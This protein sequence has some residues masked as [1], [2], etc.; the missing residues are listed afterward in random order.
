MRVLPLVLCALAA[1]TPSTQPVDTSDTGLDCA[2]EADQT[3]VLWDGMLLDTQSAMDVVVTNPCDQA[4]SLEMVTEGDEAFSVPRATLPLVAGET[5]T[6]QVL[7]QSADLEAH[8]GELVLSSLGGSARV[9]LQGHNS[10]DW[11]GDGHQGEL[12]GG[13]DCD[14]SQSSIHPDAVE[15]PCD[16]VDS[17]CDGALD[18]ASVGAKEYSDLNTAFEE[19]GNGQ[20]IWI[21]PGT[22]PLQAEVVGKDLNLLPWDDEADPPV[23]DGESSGRILDYDTGILEITGMVFANG[24][25]VGDGG[26]IRADNAQ[27]QLQGVG[28]RDNTA[29]GEGGAIAADMAHQ[30]FVASLSSFEGNTAGTHGGAVAL[31]A[32]G[33][34][35]LDGCTVDANTASG[36]DG[37]GILAE[38]Y[39]DKPAKIQITDSA[40]SNNSASGEGGGL[41]LGQAGYAQVTLREATFASNSA[42]QGGGLGA[43]TDDA[44]E[45]TLETCSF[46][47]NRADVGG[48]VHYHGASLRGAL[49]V[50]GGSYSNNS[51]T[52]QGGGFNVWSAGS[53]GMEMSS[54]VNLSACSAP[55][56]GAI[57]LDGDTNWS[58]SFEK[59]NFLSNTGTQGAALYLGSVSLLMRESKVNSNTATG[60]GAAYVGASGMLTSR[61]SNWGSGSTENEDHDVVCASGSAYDGYAGTANFICTESTCN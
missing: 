17:D 56:G 53:L 46:T 35:V 15:I 59:T 12:A 2:P 51:A 5:T 34:V 25:T 27:L 11:D 39:E 52:T 1:C 36:G 10:S 47:G 49:V 9:N 22:H 37:G 30:P 3:T 7:F 26:A 38:G 24:A 61:I 21:C 40:I 43:S 54:N 57:Y 20:T 32:A 4:V 16:G 48:A 58:T 31:R 19:A 44:T 13:D 50:D 6:I 14:D 8:T 28:F 33:E 55:S 42:A 60:G 45:L 41:G 23:L 18:A 29:T